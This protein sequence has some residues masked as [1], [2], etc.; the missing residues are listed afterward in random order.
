MSV[1]ATPANAL[2][3]WN[4]NGFIFFS[5]SLLCLLSMY[6]CWFQLLTEPSS[7]SYFRTCN[8]SVTWCIEWHFQLPKA[9]SKSKTEQEE[10][11]KESIPTRLK[12]YLYLP[13]KWHLA[14]TSRHFCSFSYDVTF[15]FFS[16]KECH[17]FRILF[18]LCM[19]NT[20]QVCANCK[21]QA[22]TYSIANTC[23]HISWNHRIILVENLLGSPAQILFSKHA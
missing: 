18:N 22:N 12:C 19:F 5:A 4:S 21:P 7:E 11:K 2:Q 23:I 20:L 16:W 10:G 17:F 13:N 3:K 1:I 15:I 14:A 8:Q 6:S 9:R